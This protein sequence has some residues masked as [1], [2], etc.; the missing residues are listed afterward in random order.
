MIQSVRSYIIFSLSL[1][2]PLKL[3]R[4]IQLCMN[5]T[6][7]RFRVG[8]KSSD[9]F[10]VRNGVKQDVY[11]YC[12]STFTYSVLLRGVQLNQDGFIKMVT[13]SCSIRL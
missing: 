2:S 10:P 8:R 13:I 6:N 5:E 4:L 7:N 3:V 12:F 1:V 11:R 9:R